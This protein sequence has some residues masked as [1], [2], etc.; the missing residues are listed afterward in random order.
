MAP[1]PSPDPSSRHEPG[2]EGM[3]HPRG[4]LAIVAIY[5]VLLVIGWLAVYFTFLGRGAPHP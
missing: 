3:G 5:A 4:T 2:P 1:S